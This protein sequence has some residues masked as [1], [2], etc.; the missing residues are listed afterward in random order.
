MSTKKVIVIGA[1]P[2]GLAAAMILAHRGF[3]VTVFEKEEEVGGRNAALRLG[4][5]TFDT[6]PTFLMMKEILEEV[7]NE[8]GAEASDHL[9]FRRLEPMYRLQFTDRRLEPTTDREKMR[10]EINRAFPGRGD[11]LDRYLRREKVRFDHLYPCLQIPYS[12]LRSLFSRN[13]FRAI[14][15]LSLNRKLFD[16]L[17]HYFKDED[18][19]LAFTFQAKYLGMSPW[20]CPGLFSILCYLE[21]AFGVYHTMGGL[22][23]NSRAMAD[24]AR[25]NGAEII[26]GEPVRQIFLEGRRARGVELESGEIVKSDDVVI[27]ADFGYAMENLFPPDFLRKYS[28][29]KLRRRRFSCST[30]MLYLGLDRIYDLPHHTIFFAKNYRQNVDEVF[31]TKKLSQD[32]SFYVRN[33]SVTDPS[34]APENGSAVYVLVPTPNLRGDIDWESEKGAF[35]DLVLDLMEKRG[36]MDNLRGAIREE[37]VITPADWETDYNVYAGAVFNLGHNLRNMIYLRPHNRFEECT[38][39]YLAGGG[40]HPGSGLPTI[41]ESG[42]IAANLISEKYGVSFSPVRKRI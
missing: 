32:I 4:E 23:E 36:G 5:Y 37:K 18:L 34:L 21:H 1:G 40:T 14:P 27:N 16:L 2:G 15:H 13:L 8:A 11:S 41:Y 6:G 31:K 17:R 33:A 30:F 22:F 24:V 38:D 29:E 10:D 20:E 28:P 12:S 39:C 7:F 35:R 3:K 25:A 19:A 9:E 26:L 42:R